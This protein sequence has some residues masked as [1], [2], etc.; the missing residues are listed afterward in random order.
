MD[1]GIDRLKDISLSLRTFARADIAYKVAFQI[2]E[3]INSTLM[4]LKHRLKDQGERPKI[5]VVT[6]YGDLPQSIVI[7]GN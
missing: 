7:R 1:Q 5:E 6:E 2:H 4:L 3:G